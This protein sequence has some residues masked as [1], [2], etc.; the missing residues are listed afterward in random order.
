MVH[1]Q[2]P[3]MSGDANLF[4]GRW[5]ALQCQTPPAT[6]LRPGAYM[7][8]VTVSGSNPPTGRGPPTRSLPPSAIAVVVGCRL[9]LTPVV[10]M[11]LVFAAEAARPGV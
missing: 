11:A 10:G 1:G 4:V 5:G 2:A 7:C 3:K 6:N 8:L 9:L